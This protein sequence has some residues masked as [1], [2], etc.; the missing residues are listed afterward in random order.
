MSAEQEAL[1][2]YTVD[3]TAK[4]W[5]SSEQ[6]SDPERQAQAVAHLAAILGRE[7]DDPDLEATLVSYENGHSVHARNYVL[8][9]IQGAYDELHLVRDPLTGLD[10]EIMHER[11]LESTYGREATAIDPENRKTK[12]GELSYLRLQIDLHNFKRINDEL[13]EEEVGDE[14]LREA[15]RELRENLREGDPMSVHRT[16]KRGDEMGVSI[17]GAAEDDALPFWRR[18][19][20]TQEYKLE[21]G[22][23]IELWAEIKAARAACP[24]PTNSKKWTRVVNERRNLGRG[25]TRDCRILY[26]GSRRI[27]DI[28]ELAVMDIGCAFGVPESRE[29]IKRINLAASINRDTVK[30]QNRAFTGGSY[31]NGEV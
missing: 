28:R 22:R 13:G 12:W 7:P 21:N 24:D 6:F 20:K 18:M 5:F 29:E 9:T 17:S 26:I 1:S 4:R 23:Q 31:R 15:V 8:T 25:Q 27:C 2:I 3:D 14:V 16:H 10:T 11:W 30:Q 19:T